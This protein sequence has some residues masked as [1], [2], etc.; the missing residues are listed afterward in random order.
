[1]K[2][3]LRGAEG[4]SLHPCLKS[5]RNQLLWT[6][7]HFD[8]AIPVSQLTQTQMTSTQSHTSHVGV[9]DQK[10]ALAVCW[11]VR[12]LTHYANTLSNLKRKALFCGAVT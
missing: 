6:A 12:D 3:S 8:S 9:A 2:K 5:I 4:K 7:H 1:M 10:S 11:P